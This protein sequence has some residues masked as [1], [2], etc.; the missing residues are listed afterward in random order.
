MDEGGSRLEEDAEQLNRPAPSL[1]RPAPHH[2]LHRIDEDLAVSGLS[3]LGH[4]ADQVDD[5]LCILILYHQLQLHLRQE[6][7]FVV[8][9]APLKCDAFLPA[10]AFDICDRHSR[11]AL[12]VQLVTQQVELLGPN[13]GFNL[14]HL[15]SLTYRR[16]HHAG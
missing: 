15:N 5:D 4:I 16:L 9:G 2:V 7:H 6:L 13:Y 12:L 3:R 8:S 10:P 11:K 1:L 14:L